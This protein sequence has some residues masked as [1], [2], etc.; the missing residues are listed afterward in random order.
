[1]ATTTTTRR[2][3]QQRSTHPVT[4]R[5]PSA[6]ALRYRAEQPTARPA[7]VDRVT[8]PPTHPEAPVRCETCARTRRFEHRTGQLARRL[9]VL[10]ACA[11]LA[12][13]TGRSGAAPGTET[14]SNTTDRIEKPAVAE[15]RIAE[16]DQPPASTPCP[17]VATLL[18]PCREPLGASDG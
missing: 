13:L 12:A 7:A 2:R 3:R 4:P 5:G 6:P 8:P 17:I 1:M 10:G 11:A 14:A 9:L 16:V 18:D 15:E